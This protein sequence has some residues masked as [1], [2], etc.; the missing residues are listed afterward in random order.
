MDDEGIGLD[1]CDGLADVRLQDG[2]GLGRPGRPDAGVFWMASLKP[3]SVKVGMPQSVWGM[4]MISWC[5]FDPDSTRG[6]QN[7]K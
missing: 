1:A 7:P 6:P 4:R 5:G 2:E 3:S